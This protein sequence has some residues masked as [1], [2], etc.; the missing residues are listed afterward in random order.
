MRMVSH[1]SMEIA[2]MMTPAFTPVLRTL[3]MTASTQIALGI[4]TMTKIKMGKT[5][6]RTVEQTAMIPTPLCMKARKTRGTMG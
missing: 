5:Q 2:M 6:R 1:P 4:Q 3:G